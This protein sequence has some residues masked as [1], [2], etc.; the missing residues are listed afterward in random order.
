MRHRLLTLSSLFLLASGWANS[1]H[2]QSFVGIVKTLE[3]GATIIRNGESKPAVRGMQVQKGDKV[4]TDSQGAVGLVFS[5][6][7]VLSMGP[8]SE[9]V[10]DDYVFEPADK[11]LSFVAS[12]LKGTLC[13][14]SGQITKLAPE[15]V[16]INIPH[17]TIGVRGTRV[18][19]RVE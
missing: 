17:A 15:S 6:D 9:V 8:N 10:L 14:L 2:A 13:F 11:R 3:G 19:A 4:K 5:D 1:A 12:L 18:L 16:R 7:A